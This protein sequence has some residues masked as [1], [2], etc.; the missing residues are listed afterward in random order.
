MPAKPKKPQR[1]TPSFSTL[2]QS[3]DPW[4]RQPKESAQNY[5]AFCLYREMG[6]DERT[7]LKV[8]K[9]VGKGGPFIGVLSRRQMWVVRVG[10]WDDHL[11]QKKREVEIEV[12]QRMT[13]RHINL[14]M[15]MQ[16]IGGRRIQAIIKDLDEGRDPKVSPSDAR[17]LIETGIRL[18]RLNRGQPET[19]TETRQI[20]M[21]ELSDEQLERIAN[22]EDPMQVLRG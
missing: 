10:A 12:V 5:R 13:E 15:G 14:A 4:R 1:D 22:G 17:K 21:D 6:P 20:N 16:A 11:E 19:V 7:H 9:A 3:R 2:S 18:E 8:A